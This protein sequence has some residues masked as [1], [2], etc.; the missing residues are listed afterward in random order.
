MSHRAMS[1]VDFGFN[2]DTVTNTNNSGIGSLRQA[3]TNANTLTGDAS[4]TQ[5]GK[6]GAVEN[7]VFMISNGTSANGL[8]SANNYFT[9][10]A[11][12]YN[13]ATVTPTSAM[14]TVSSTLVLD[15]QTQPGWTANPIIELRGDSAGAKHQR[16]HSECQQHNPAR[17][18][19]E[20][21]HWRRRVLTV[22]KQPHHSGQLDRR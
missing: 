18:H 15:A 17:L 22:W 19:R 7:L 20:P 3:M 5:S 2:F 14:P 10:S 6:T 16:A 9:T 12:A 21:V 1:G 4:L 13:V 11:G 8:R